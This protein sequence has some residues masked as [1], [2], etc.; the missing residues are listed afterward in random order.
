MSMRLIGYNQSRIQQAR[1][2]WLI[3]LNFPQRTRVV[4]VS[5]QK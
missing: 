2:E 3:E 1:M 4:F 5:S